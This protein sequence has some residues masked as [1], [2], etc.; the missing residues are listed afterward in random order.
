M[1]NPASIIKLLVAAVVFFYLV[2]HFVDKSKH[3]ETKK[4]T[5]Q[6]K[7]LIEK[8]GFDI[9]IAEQIKDYGVTDFVKHSRNNYDSDVS[10][11]EFMA[12]EIQIP[13]NKS[14]S[15]VKDFYKIALD[16]GYTVYVAGQNY[17]EENDTFVI[18]KGYNKFDPLRFEATNGLNYDLETEDII[19]RL[20]KW[21]QLYG[22]ELHI[23]SYDNVVGKFKE[24]P[25]DVSKLAQEIY[26]F[27]PDTV[28]QGVGSVEELTK[29]IEENG[30][31]YLWWD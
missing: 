2:G 23:V 4:L 12:V 8:L 9:K 27:C 14:E 30:T 25:E 17:V 31:L 26:E 3:L 6:E 20:E 1:D 28:E 29:F 7:N 18:F 15:V 11:D 22:I 13:R 24:L 21:D 16:L 5:K 10:E 19:T